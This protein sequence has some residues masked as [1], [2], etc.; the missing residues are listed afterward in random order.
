MTNETIKTLSIYKKLQEIV[1]RYCM[2]LTTDQVCDV[3]RHYLDTWKNMIEIY[4]SN[5]FTL[6]KMIEQTSDDKYLEFLNNWS[7]QHSMQIY[8]Q[9]KES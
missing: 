8:A 4:P 3:A 2:M 1:D 7:I 9:I 5:I 6:D